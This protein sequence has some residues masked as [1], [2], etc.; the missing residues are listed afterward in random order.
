MYVNER[1]TLPRVDQTDAVSIWELILRGGM[2]VHTSQTSVL[3]LTN[4]YGGTWG[5]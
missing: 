3:V 5:E 1:Q 4:F 2:A